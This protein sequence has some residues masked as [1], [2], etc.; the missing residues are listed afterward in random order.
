MS[1]Q[2]RMTIGV[3]SDTSLLTYSYGEK[4]YVRYSNMERVDTLADMLGIA[5]C[6]AI[7]TLWVVPGS[8]PSVGA[9]DLMMIEGLQ[10]VGSSNRDK[11]PRFVLAWKTEG[12]TKSVKIA[13]PEHDKR[14]PFADC[15][16]PKTLLYAILYLQ[17]A[18][19]HEVAWSPGHT[20]LD[21]LYGGLS[22]H[23]QWLVTPD[24]PDVVKKETN[25]AKDWRWHRQLTAR[26]CGDGM[27]FHLFDKNSMY[28]AACTSANVG[29]G[30]PL[31]AQAHGGKDA[32]NLFRDPAVWNLRVP[33][34]WKV[35]EAWLWTP[36]LEY[37]VQKEEAWTPLVTEAYIW[38]TYHQALRWWGEHL[39]NA[40]QALIKTTVGTLYTQPSAR[41][42]AYQAVKRIAT[43]GLGWLA[44]D[45]PDNKLYRPDWWSQVVATAH[46]NMGFKVRQLMDRGIVPCYINVDSVGLVSEGPDIERYTSIILNRRDALGGFKHVCS[47]PVTSSLVAAL[48]GSFRDAQ[49]AVKEVQ[50]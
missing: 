37:L 18:L 30:T 32:A 20:G 4:Q 6:H 1:F 38:P 14:W 10:V 46:K 26:E 16:D 22:N 34:M 41:D 2:S 29:E 39:W 13:F 40:R 35:G 12:N 50:S 23:K 24:L 7:D 47:V 11:T 8:L 44:M 42:Y 49:N 36:E 43:Q 28:L 5:H 31:Y 21:L 9:K 19:E 15:T 25:F 17:D 3:L 48:R 27:Y 45:S 33:G